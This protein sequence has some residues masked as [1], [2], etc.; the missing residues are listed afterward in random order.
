MTILSNKI[1]DNYVD[2]ITTESNKHILLENPFYDQEDWE[3]NFSNNSLTRKDQSG[4]NLQPDK[5]NSG[6][7]IPAIV[8]QKN[9]VSGTLVLKNYR[10]NSIS[11]QELLIKQMNLFKLSIKTS[12]DLVIKDSAAPGTTP[13]Y[14]KLK[15]YIKT[16]VLSILATEK[17]LA[18]STNG[19]TSTTN[20]PVVVEKTLIEKLK[21]KV[22]QKLNELNDIESYP[23]LKETKEKVVEGIMLIEIHRPRRTPLVQSP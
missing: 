22:L 8:V 5:D 3:F 13:E 7:A 4:N 2:T 11:P 17:I 10:L 20:D 23:E 15:S 9:D 21:E 6:N 12:K 1:S 19:T 16:M 14:R 18:S